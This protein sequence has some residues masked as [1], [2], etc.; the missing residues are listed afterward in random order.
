MTGRQ[1]LD[2]R[3][4]AMAVILGISLG[5]WL[6]FLIRAKA[7]NVSPNVMA[8]PLDGILLCTLYHMFMIRCP[9]CGKSLGHLTGSL[10][11]FSLFR[12]PKR[13]RFCPHCTI[14]FE[15]ELQTRH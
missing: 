2:K 14:D 12:F 9:R 8:I 3:V 13:V 7:G 1:Y 6:F 15:D 11:D 5:T 10:C 4:A